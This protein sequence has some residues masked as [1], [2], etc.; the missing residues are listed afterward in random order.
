MENTV[1]RFRLALLVKKIARV[2]NQTKVLVTMSKE[3]ERC[4]SGEINV[5]SVDNVKNA[6]Y[7]LLGSVGKE[8]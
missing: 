3:S 2:E 7:Y 4:C 1:S 5:I 8:H 6:V